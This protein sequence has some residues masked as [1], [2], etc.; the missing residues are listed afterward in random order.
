[1]NVASLNQPTYGPGSHL[2]ATALDHPQLIK[3]DAAPVRMFFQEYDQY[4]RKVTESA[5]QLFA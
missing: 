3:K 4:A 2:V 1:M 5:C